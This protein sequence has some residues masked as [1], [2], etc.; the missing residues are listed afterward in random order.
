[1]DLVKK[2]FKILA[3]RYLSEHPLEDAKKMQNDSMTELINDTPSFAED[4]LFKDMYPIIFMIEYITLK[5]K[6]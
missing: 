6:G 3:V 5:M 2:G 4:E 1:M